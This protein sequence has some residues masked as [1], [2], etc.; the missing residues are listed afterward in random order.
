MPKT[1]N[2]QECAE[3]LKI[4]P[5]TV[6]VRAATGELP[7]A[8]V[9]RAWVFLEEDVIAYLRAK[10]DG[11]VAKRH[12]NSPINRLVRQQ[13]EDAN[14]APSA[15]APTERKWSKRRVPISQR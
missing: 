3:L 14:S 10:I 7:G 4:H 6:Q 1:L 12:Q 11:Q 13:A 8:K 15:V 2:I 5:D 9:G